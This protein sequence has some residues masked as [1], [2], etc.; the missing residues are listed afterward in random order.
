MEETMI[1]KAKIH[2]LIEDVI[3]NTNEAYNHFSQYGNN[4][5][6]YYE[7]AKNIYWYYQN[8]YSLSPSTD[9]QPAFKSMEEMELWCH[10][11]NFM[12][13]KLYANK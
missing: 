4:W 11:H 2:Y 9:R 13:K 6:S 8:L 3:P 1:Q 10:F 7:K 5:H 12:K